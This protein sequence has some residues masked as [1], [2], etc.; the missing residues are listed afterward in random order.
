MSFWSLKIN[1]SAINGRVS[2]LRS[3][4]FNDL[5]TY[6]GASGHTLIFMSSLKELSIPLEAG[7]FNF[8]SLITANSLA[9]P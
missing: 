4:F 8:K 6:L 5:P 3:I 1:L 2:A 9:T 7:F